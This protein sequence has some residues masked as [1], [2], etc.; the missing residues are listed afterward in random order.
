MLCWGNDE[1]DGFVVLDMQHKH[2]TT[3]I[4]HTHRRPEAPMVVNCIAYR[5][6]HSICPDTLWPNNAIRVQ[7]EQNFCCCALCQRERETL[8]LWVCAN[9]VCSPTRLAIASQ[10]PRICT[11]KS[12]AAR[13]NKTHSAAV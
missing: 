13:H 4:T 9:I 7:Y 12:T 8:L 1:H 11:R 2:Y 10:L 5:Y 6:S 3:H